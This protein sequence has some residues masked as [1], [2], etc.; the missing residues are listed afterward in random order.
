VV[1]ADDDH[2]FASA[3]KALL[4]HDNR[5]EVVGYGANGEEAVSLTKILQ[6]ALVLVD[7]HMPLV[8]GV[9][10]ARQILELGDSDVV[11]VTS[12]NE[13]TDMA[14]AREVGVSNVLHKSVGLDELAATISRLAAGIA[15]R[16]D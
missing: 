5:L 7:L 10:A 8:D 14:R 16:L 11:L 6:P 9:E 2:L 15:D 12:S 3:L 1:I 13:P 4:A